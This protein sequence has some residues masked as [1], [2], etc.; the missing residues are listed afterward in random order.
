VHNT[1]FRMVVL[2]RSG[3]NRNCLEHV[4]GDLPLLIVTRMKS[5]FAIQPFASVIDPNGWAVF[6]ID[7]HRKAVYGDHLIPRGLVGRLEKVLGCRALVVLHDQEG[8]PLLVTTHR[9]DQHLTVGLPATITRYEQATGL[10]SVERVVVDREGM[11]AEFLA[12]RAARRTYGGHRVANRPVQR[13]GAV[14]RGE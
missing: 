1:D 2:R 10:H 6:Y 7:G 8:H 4:L 13:V 14:P 12:A 5:D 9:G 3:L 11:A